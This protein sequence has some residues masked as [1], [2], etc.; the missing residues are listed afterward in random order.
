V[1]GDDPPKPGSDPVHPQ[2]PVHPDSDM[3][4]TV[5]KTSEV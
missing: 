2:N 1:S 3:Q 4:E 5:R